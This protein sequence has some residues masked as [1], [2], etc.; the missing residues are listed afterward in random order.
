MANIQQDRST[1]P[2]VDEQAQNRISRPKGPPSTIVN[3]RFPLIILEQLDRYLDWVE[4]H[5]GETVNRGTITRRALVE[6]LE[7]H[8]QTAKKPS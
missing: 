7:R 1:T 3:V 6:F 4:T 8:T 5:T 2:L